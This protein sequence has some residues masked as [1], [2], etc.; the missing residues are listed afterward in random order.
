MTQYDPRYRISGHAVLL[1]GSHMSRK[2]LPLRYVFNVLN[3]WLKTNSINFRCLESLCDPVKA[4]SAHL[5]DLMICAPWATETFGCLADGRDHS[6][7]CSSR[8]VPTPCLELCSG[9][10]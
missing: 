2:E 8:S 3:P 9:N 7:C 6:Q 10:L 5:T 1:E 4:A